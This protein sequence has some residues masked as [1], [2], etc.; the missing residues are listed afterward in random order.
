MKITTCTALLCA[1]TTA[2]AFA[3][4]KA[5]MCGDQAEMVMQVVA[6][7]QS[8]VAAVKAEQLVVDALDADTSAYA[9]VVPAVVAWVYTLPEDQLGDAVGESWSAACLAQ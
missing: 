2:P 9:G 6:A 5:A 7:R 4:D 3:Q 1:L 8:G